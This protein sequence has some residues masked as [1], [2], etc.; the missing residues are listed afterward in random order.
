MTTRIADPVKDAAAIAARLDEAWE[1]GRPIAPLTESDGLQVADAY[2]VQS[3][4]TDLRA[5][6][7]EQIVGRKIGLTSLAMQKQMGVDEP[8]YGSL[9][10][11][12]YFPAQGSRAEIP[13]EPFIEPRLEGELAF[14]LGRP[15]GDGPVTAQRVLA[16]TEALAVS[17]EI[18]D[19]R[20]DQWRI[21]LADTVA[22]NASYGGFTLGPW[23][24]A[25][26]TEDLR[27]LGM[28]ITRTGTPV[29]EGIGA[30]AL[31]HP[32][33]AVAWLANK[34]ATFG[35][36]LQP[37]DIV[38]SGSLGPAVAVEAGDVFVL[39]FHGQ[40]PLTVTFT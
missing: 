37:G 11:S 27:T 18:V 35:V 23:S 22:D 21:A 31:G 29:A 4:W 40:P 39:Q 10:A 28:Q 20:I 24:R 25:L 1:S 16:A 33:N 9:W 17:V 3:A 5:S 14:L 26:R 8:D 32:A 36:S 34:L 7:G 38:L 6:R 19:S 15:L 12:R 2:A 13:I 30:A